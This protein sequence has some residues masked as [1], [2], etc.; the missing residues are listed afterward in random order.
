MIDWQVKTTRALDSSNPP[1]DRW[2]PDGELNVWVGALDR[3]VDDGRGEHSAL[4]YD[5]PVTGSQ[6]TYT[7]HHHT[8]T[9]H[10]RDYPGRRVAGRPR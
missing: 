6:R 3:Q 9:N 8:Y 4:I 2:F 7:N 10:H 5:S 1:F